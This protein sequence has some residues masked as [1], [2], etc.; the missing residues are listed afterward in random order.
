MGIYLNPE[1]E[2]FLQ[3][4]NNQIYVDKSK[5]IENTNRMIGSGECKICV[6]RPRR[7]GKSTDANML[8]AYY[9]K[10]C[11]S[12]SLFNSLNISQTDNYLNHL[13]KHNVIHL[14]MQDF[15]SK[16]HN[17]ERMLM[18]VTKLVFREIE[19]L[20]SCIDYFNTNDLVQI[21]EDV[22]SETRD[23]FIFIC[24]ICKDQSM[25]YCQRIIN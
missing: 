24:S 22:Y 14:N 18:L 9:S 1:N 25:G 16:T 4:L 20:Y 3:A 7:F 11:E 21:F 8:V 13:N 6:S 19:R 12:S 10:G 23:F 17:I 5:L 15:L 2:L